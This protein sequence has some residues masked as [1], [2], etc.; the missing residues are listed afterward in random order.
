M[1]FQSV[2]GDCAITVVPYFLPRLIPATYLCLKLLCA[3]GVNLPQKGRIAGSLLLCV[4][5]SRKLNLTESIQEGKEFLGKR[6]I[7][8]PA[9][10]QHPSLLTP[11][12]GQELTP[13]QPSAD[14]HH[15]VLLFFGSVSMKHLTAVILLLFQKTFCAENCVVTHHI[16]NLSWPSST[17][18]LYPEVT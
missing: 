13:P 17:R 12:D 9:A 15:Q 14:L 6:A 11:G 4:H 10:S 5:F 1:Q 7:C 8:D 3:I 2:Y 16:S 18:K